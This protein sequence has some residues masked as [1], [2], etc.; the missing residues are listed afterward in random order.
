MNPF[1]KL[2]TAKIRNLIAGIQENI[3]ELEN[4]ACMSLNDFKQN[5]R[6]YAIAEHHLRRALE[7]ILTI[8]THILSRIP[9]VRMKDYQSIIESL[10][11][12]NV[13]PKD[14]AEKNKKLSAYRNR[15]VHLYW[16]ISEKE[17]YEII[18]QHL[19]DIDMF[20]NY[21]LGYIRKS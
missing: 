18:K 6:N 15:L 16:E 10:G 5:K 21:F 17:L 4:I 8:G 13:I 9:N 12:Q 3:K 2:D 20:C 7:G 1:A 14:F 11:A 19:K